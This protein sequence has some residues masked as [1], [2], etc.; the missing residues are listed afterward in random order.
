M[1]LV[2]FSGLPGTGKSALA[3]AVG[4][5]LG[6]PVFAKD[7]LQAALYA[8]GMNA[9]E[10][11]R[12]MAGYAGYELLGVLAERQLALGQSAILDSVAT[13]ERIRVGWRDLA[14]RHGAVFRVVECVCSDVALHRTRLVNRERGIPGWDE[15]TWAKVEQVR[16]VYQPWGDFPRLVVDA[17][18]S[19]EDNLRAVLGYVGRV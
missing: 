17:V 16:E 4:R 14:V 19:R 13:F 11:L 12:Q 6:M 9:S 1:Q 7:W 5:Q 15:L 8:S 18:N 2:I 3:E 10:A